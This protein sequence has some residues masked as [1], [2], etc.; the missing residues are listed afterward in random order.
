M[1]KIDIEGSEYYVFDNTSDS[2]L[3]KTKMVIIEFHD[4]TIPGCSKRVLDKME[5]LGFKH[6]IYN[7]NYVFYK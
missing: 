1:I 6:K 4:R 3:K 7:E 5:K 2:W